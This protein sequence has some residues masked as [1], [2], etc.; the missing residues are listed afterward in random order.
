MPANLCR[1]KESRQCV[2]EEMLKDFSL[3]NYCREGTI[4]LSIPFISFCETNKFKTKQL[5]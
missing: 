5:L 1:M 3:S 2:I 4:V